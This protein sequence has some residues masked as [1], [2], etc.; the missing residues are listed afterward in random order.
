[1]KTIQL[2][3]D[4]NGNMAIDEYLP[5]THKSAFK[6]FLEG[7]GYNV[8]TH[9]DQDRR[10]K[11]EPSLWRKRTI[12]DIDWTDYN[13]YLT[14]IRN[15]D[16]EDWEITELLGSKGTGMAVTM[17]VGKILKQYTKLL[18][19]DGQNISEESL[20]QFCKDM[21]G[22]SVK[23]IAT[24]NRNVRILL[25]SGC[26]VGT[27]T[28]GEEC[29]TG[30]TEECYKCPFNEKAGKPIQNTIDIARHKEVWIEALRQI[31]EDKKGEQ[32]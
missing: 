16:K 13:V 28:Y 18:E 17:R 9:T 2:I 32:K 6:L 25:E 21:A 26:K 24:I 23:T 20:V 19:L 3:T 7:L 5:D 27:N 12:R 15:K 10:F 14:I 22:N 30:F 31:V 29:K 1:M 11:D 8:I 4:K